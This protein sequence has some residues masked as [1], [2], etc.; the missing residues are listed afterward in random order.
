MHVLTC[1]AL[2][3]PYV[4]EGTNGKLVHL[5]LH[6]YANLRCEATDCFTCGMSALEEK[7]K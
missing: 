2:H 4:Q 5:K 7:Y 6:S 1:F 3:R